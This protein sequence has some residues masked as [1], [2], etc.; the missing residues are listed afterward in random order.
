MS[1]LMRLLWFVIGVL[2]LTVARPIFVPAKE[3]AEPQSQLKSLLMR[4]VLTDGQSLA[5]VKKFCERRIAEM[6]HPP[7]WSSWQR[8][9]ERIRQ[10][11]LD[12]IVFRGVR[13]LP[14]VLESA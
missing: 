2:L 12:S 3:P 11:V 6:P 1:R 10:N 14:M 8:E 5:E 7:S 4:P 9:A 13:G